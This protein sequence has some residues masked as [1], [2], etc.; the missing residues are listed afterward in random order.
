MLTPRAKETM[1][2]DITDSTEASFVTAESAQGPTFIA[3]EGVEQP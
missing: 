3:G 2:I 1:Q